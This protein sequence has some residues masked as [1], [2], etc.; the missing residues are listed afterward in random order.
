MATADAHQ[1]ALE[2]Y[3][4]RVVIDTNSPEVLRQVEPI[5]PPGWAQCPAT[6]ADQRVGITTDD[7]F[8]FDI[9]VDD[10]PT[11]ADVELDVALGV[12]DVRLRFYIAQHAPERIFVHAG[13]VAHRGR[14]IVIP[15]AGFS[16]KTTLV[17]ELVRSGATYYSDDYAVLDRHGR[18][19]PYAKPLS[20]RDEQ[21]VQTDHPIATFGGA[22]GEEPIRVGLVVVTHYRPGAE[23]Q[24][25]RISPG[26]GVLALL[27]NTV[28]AQ[29]RPAEALEAVTHVMQ[30]ALALESERGEAAAIVDELLETLSE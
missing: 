26:E 20:I 30:D 23:W 8:F 27:A 3:G 24:P 10:V 19:H 6:D 9:T 5:L 18:V 29:E 1:L 14:A 28:P 25:R 11:A 17:S 21:S 13:V 22:A 16:G 2:A 15:G 12:L 4:V 7:G